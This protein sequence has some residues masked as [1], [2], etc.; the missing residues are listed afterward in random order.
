MALVKVI[1]I[2]D[3]L[4][5]DLSNVA[6]AAKKQD[7]ISIYLVERAGRQA[8]L[9]ISADRSIDIHHNKVVTIK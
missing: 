3:E 4:T 7:G 9:R 8:V 1:G 6:D 5:F 2:G